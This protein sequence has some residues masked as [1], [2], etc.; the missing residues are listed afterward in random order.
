MRRALL[1]VAGR[2]PSRCHRCWSVPMTPVQGATG[3][4][5]DGGTGLGDRGMPPAQDGEGV[6]YLGPGDTLSPTPGRWHY[7]PYP[8]PGSLCSLPRAGVHSVPYPGTGSCSP[9]RQPPPLPVPLVFP[10][11]VGRRRRLS[12]VGRQTSGRRPTRGSGSGSAAA[13]PACAGRTSSRSPGARRA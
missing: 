11:R 5:G 12:A 13:A 6:P 4:Y 8:G 1:A 9:Q 10:L 7:V 3:G 2:T